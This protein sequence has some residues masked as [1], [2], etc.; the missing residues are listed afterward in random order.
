[1]VDIPDHEDE[2]EQAFEMIRGWVNGAENPRTLLVDLHNRHKIAVGGPNYLNLQKAIQHNNRLFY[3]CPT[4]KSKMG[5]NQC[6]VQLHPFFTY[7]SL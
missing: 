2:M 3:L 6:I 1:M 7:Y 4:T 5:R